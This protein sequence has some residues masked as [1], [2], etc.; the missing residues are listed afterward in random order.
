MCRV[1]PRCGRV[2]GE[3][4]R[5]AAWRVTVSVVPAP[6]AGSFGRPDM[7]VNCLACLQMAHPPM[8]ARNAFPAREL[9]FELIAIRLALY[10]N[11]PP[12]FQ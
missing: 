8:A 1:L 11:A 3:S 7:S 4:S 5:A 12:G 2:R 9:T 10:A 6:S